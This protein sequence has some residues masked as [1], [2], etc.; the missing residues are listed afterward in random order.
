MTWTAFKVNDA[1]LDSSPATVRIS[2]TSS[3]STLEAGK[4]L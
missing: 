1:S 4:S 2:I 3:A